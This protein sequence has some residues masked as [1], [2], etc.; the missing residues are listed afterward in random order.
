MSYNFSENAE[1]LDLPRE[2]W[3]LL[4]EAFSIPGSSLPTSSQAVIRV[5]IDHATK[6]IM[7]FVVFQTV[8]MAQPALVYPE[9]QHLQVLDNIYKSIDN[10]LSPGEYYFVNIADPALQRRAEHKGFIRVPGEIFAKVKKVEDEEVEVE[11]VFIPNE[12]IGRVTV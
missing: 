7:G 5:A 1:I 8:L 10:E 3:H 2:Q 9:F 4:T 11:S 6:K 12:E